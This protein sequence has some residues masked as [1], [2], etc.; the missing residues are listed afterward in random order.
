MIF[1]IIYVVIKEDANNIKGMSFYVI[2][3]HRDDVY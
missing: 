3:R 1:D 2:G